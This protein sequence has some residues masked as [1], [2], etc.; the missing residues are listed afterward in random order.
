MTVV[1]MLL[2]LTTIFLCV[3]YGQQEAENSLGNKKWVD[4]RFLVAVV[5]RKGARVRHQGIKSNCFNEKTA[6]ALENEQM[7][8][9]NLACGCVFDLN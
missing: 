9:A 7:S 6:L 5:S 3:Q 2:T 1:W 4:V 8:T